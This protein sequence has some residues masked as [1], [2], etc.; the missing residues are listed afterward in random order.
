MNDEQMEAALKRADSALWSQAELDDRGLETLC[1]HAE[2]P[3]R[4]PLE[5]V[6]SSEARELY[7]A[8]QTYTKER[9]PRYTSHVARWI[10]LPA[11]AALLLVMML[12]VPMGP[13][14][15]GEFTAR[16]FAPHALRDFDVLRVRPGEDAR[17]IVRGTNIHVGERLGFAYHEAAPGTKSVTIV[18]FDGARIDWL[19]PQDPAAPTGFVLDP[20][21]ARGGQRLP[22]DV[23]LD[24]A[25]KPGTVLFLA[26][27]DLGPTELEKLIREERFEG[28]PQVAVIPFQLVAPKETSR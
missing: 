13:E 25:L 23:E 8:A 24:P 17:P 9:A 4:L 6:D 5:L 21:R 7:L 20:A 12:R 15:D 3:G 10:W 22:E 18:A 28:H 1:T 2:Q 27:F 26:G 16:G 14:T 19:Y 11:G